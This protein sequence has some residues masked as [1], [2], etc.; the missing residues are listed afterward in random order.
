MYLPRL[1]LISGHRFGIRGRRPGFTLIEVLVGALILASAGTVLAR[2]LAAI[3]VTDAAAMQVLGEAETLR[4][5]LNRMDLELAWKPLEKRPDF[6]DRD[7]PHRERPD[8]IIRTRCRATSRD[9]ERLWAVQSTL[10]S[11]RWKIPLMIWHYRYP[12]PETEEKP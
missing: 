10:S 5:Q 7:E 4:D 6:F 11:G 3:A 12:I 9:A 2:A 1:A 8:W